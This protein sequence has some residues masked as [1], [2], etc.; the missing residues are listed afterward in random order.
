MMLCKPSGWCHAGTRSRGL[1]ALAAIPLL[2]TSH[3]AAQEQTF[4]SPD[5]AVNALVA[6]AEAKDTNAFHAIFGPAAHDLVSPDVVQASES[7]DVFVRRLTEKVQQD[8]QSDS[9][10]TLRLGA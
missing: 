1:L 6:A 10:I 3:Y 4:P 2:A 7:F 9:R 8:R 5:Q